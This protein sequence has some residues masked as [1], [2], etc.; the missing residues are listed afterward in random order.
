MLNSLSLKLETNRTPHRRCFLVLLGAR[1]GR[2][3]IRRDRPEL[4]MIKAREFLRK[5]L[6][7]KKVSCLLV[8]VAN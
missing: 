8:Y 4:C 3:L 2:N 1:P 7:G 6:V 5:W